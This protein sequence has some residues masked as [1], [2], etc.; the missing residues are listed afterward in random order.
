M[1]TFDLGHLRFSRCPVCGSWLG[2]DERK[3][4][5]TRRVVDD[6][7]RTARHVAATRTAT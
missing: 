7:E 5:Q 3:P 4:D 6:H 2:L 1:K